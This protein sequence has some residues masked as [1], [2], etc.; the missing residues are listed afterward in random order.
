MFKHCLALS[1]CARIADREY[2]A[3]HVSKVDDATQEMTLGCY[4]KLG[5]LVFDQLRLP[6]NHIPDEFYILK[7]QAFI[8]DIN[9]HLKWK[10]S[11]QPNEE[12]GNL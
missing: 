11:I 8:D 1:Y 7:A 10:S 5:R 4:Y 12:L 2:V 9:Q 6:N 3:F